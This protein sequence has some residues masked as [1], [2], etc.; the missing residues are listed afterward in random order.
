MQLIIFLVAH[1]SVSFFVH[2]ETGVIF[3]VFIRFAVRSAAPIAI[4]LKFSLTSNLPKRFQSFGHTGWRCCYLYSLGEVGGREQ[5]HQNHEK[6]GEIFVG[7]FA[8]EVA[9][10]VFVVHKAPNGVV[11]G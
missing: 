7:D 3:N 6:H 11:Q 8:R 4:P 2:A 5:K 1:A 10:D 9:R